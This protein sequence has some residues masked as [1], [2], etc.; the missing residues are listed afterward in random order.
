MSSNVTT[1]ER[2]FVPNGKKRCDSSEKSVD[3]P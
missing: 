1:C 3:D 2:A